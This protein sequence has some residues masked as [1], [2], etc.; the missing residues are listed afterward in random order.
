MSG[1]R[2]HIS[3]SHTGNPADGIRLIDDL[4]ARGVDVRHVS[5]HA[6][7]HARRDGAP[8]AGA[9]PGASPR[10]SRCS[11]TRMSAHACVPTRLPLITDKPSLGPAWPDMVVI[12]HA[13]QSPA[14]GGAL[15][16]PKRRGAA[17]TWSMRPSTC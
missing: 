3:L 10:R 7:V 8:A 14:R 9:A 16:G 1:V 12:A 6:Q 5:V 2:A 15:A 11:A 17:S 13:P 4:A